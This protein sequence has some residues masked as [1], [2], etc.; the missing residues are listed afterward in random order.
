MQFASVSDLTK[1]QIAGLKKSFGRIYKVRVCDEDYLVRRLYK[2]DWDAVNKL[3]RDNPQVSF[4]DIDEKVVNTALIGPLPDI[5]NGGWAALPA[6]VVPTLSMFIRAKSGFV[7]PELS[8]ESNITVE[9]LDEEETEPARPDAATIAALKAS[10]TFKLKLLGIEDQMF[11]VRP[12]TR[13]EWK[14]VLKTENQTD[15]DMAVCAKSV[16]W[17][18]SVNWD[19]QP[20]GFCDTITQ[21]VLSIS[22]YSAPS[23][24]E[25]L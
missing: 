12:V 25:E 18:K 24:V 23:A 4:A 5:A 3:K 16:M 17:P 11:V 8:E 13:V 9:P 6:G 1:E 19:D 22:G 10:T 2:P 7:V 15:Q 21:F 20:A 14:Q